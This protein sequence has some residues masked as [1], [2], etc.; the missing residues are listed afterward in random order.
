[1]KASRLRM[2][3]S[4]SQRKCILDLRTKIII[5]G[6]KPSDIPIEV[7]K[8]FEDLGKTMDRER[9]EKLWKK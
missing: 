4:V 5:L 2:G 8:K 3:I 1:M 9:Y 7:G 6:C